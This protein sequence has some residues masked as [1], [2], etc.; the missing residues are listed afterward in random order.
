MELEPDS[1]A[2][3]PVTRALSLGN[4]G[5]VV[6]CRAGVVHLLGRDVVDCGTSRYGGDARSVTGGVA[7]DVAVRG[8]LDS[9]LGVV[10]LGTAGDGPVFLFRLAVDYETGECV[11]MML[12]WIR[13]NLDHLRFHIQWA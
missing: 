4:L 9:L 6:L 13:G 2:S 12:V 7:S 8:V 3:I 11:Y 1:A 5:E 10:V